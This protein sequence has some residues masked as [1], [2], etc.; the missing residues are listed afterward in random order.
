MTK[1]F[2]RTTKARQHDRHALRHW[3]TEFKAVFVTKET[4]CSAS[5]HFS[6]DANSLAT[7]YEYHGNGDARR[8]IWVK[9]CF[10]KRQVWTHLQK[11]AYTLSGS[12]TKVTR[13]R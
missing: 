10:S 12:S 3:Q 4:D 9:E 13:G 6:G 7:V 8:V 5:V 1:S 11:P 2:Q